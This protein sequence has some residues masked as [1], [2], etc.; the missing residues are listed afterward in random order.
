MAV[1]FFIQFVGNWDSMLTANSK[2]VDNEK[3]SIMPFHSLRHSFSP[4]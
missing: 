1:S 3:V 2:R 4:Y